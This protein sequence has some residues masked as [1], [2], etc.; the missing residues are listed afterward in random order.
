M[1]A[2][3]CHGISAHQLAASW[4]ET[5]PDLDR[6]AQRLGLHSEDNC[7]RCVEELDSLVDAAECALLSSGAAG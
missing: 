3:V 2:C 6:L 1:Y 4:A 5:H 7:G